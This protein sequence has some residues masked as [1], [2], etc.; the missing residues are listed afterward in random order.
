MLSDDD[1]GMGRRVSLSIAGLCCPAAL[2]CFLLFAV[3][4]FHRGE[5]A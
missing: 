3:G 4:D 5:V 2:E 1:C